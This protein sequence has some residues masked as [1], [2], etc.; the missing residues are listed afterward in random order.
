MLTSKATSM[1]SE[2]VL[3]FIHSTAGNPVAFQYLQVNG[4]STVAFQTHISV[5]LT[6]SGFQCA[7]LSVE[8]TFVFYGML[9]RY[10]ASSGGEYLLYRM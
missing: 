2:I 3:A 9:Y 10:A 4:T 5:S 6:N 7:S 1:T 8:S